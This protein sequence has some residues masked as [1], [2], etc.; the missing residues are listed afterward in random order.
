M[1]HNM[2]TSIQFSEGIYDP[3]TKTFT[4]SLEMEP[5]P[6]M[7]SQVHEVLKV[8]DN[9]HMMPEWYETQRG[10]ERKTMEIAYTCRQEIARADCGSRIW[11]CGKL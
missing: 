6:G 8:T 10:Q 11:D 5:V 7:K 2:G 4:Y 3:A 9:N 1:D